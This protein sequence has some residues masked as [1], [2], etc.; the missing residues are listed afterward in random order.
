MK[1]VLVTVMLAAGVARANDAF[2]RAEVVDAVAVQKAPASES[3]ASWA[4]VPGRTFRVTAQRSVHLH[5]K[6]ANAVLAN[7]QVDAIE[8]EVRAVSSPD[9]LAVRLEWADAT[10]DV[11]REDEVNTFADTVALEVPERFGAGLRLPAVSMGDDGATVRVT[12]LRAVKGGAQESRYVAAGFGSL[13][14]LGPPATS[15]ALQ[16]NATTR[17]WAALV[18]LPASTVQALTPIAF[19]VWD[20]ARQ[21]RSGNKRLSAWHFVRVPGKPIDAQYLSELAWGAAP[22][23]L[24]DPARGKALAEGVCVACHHLPGRAFAPVGVA[25]SLEMIGAIATPSYLRDSIV[26]P[27]AVIVREPNPNQHYAAGAPR[28]ANGA[29]P[30]ADAFRWS[31]VGADGKRV[32]KMPPFANFS[33]E[34]IADLVAFLRTLDGRTQEPPP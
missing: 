23:E 27:S 30:N 17:R 18:R 2:L 20:G 9:G 6:K 26:E 5:D 7:R 34:Q 15:D 21:E 16:W 31:S 22:G 28:D 3:D 14:R 10:Q 4:Q 12:M 19:A 32:S 11:V 29:A 8:V 25:P 33:K 13:T 24:G 1:T